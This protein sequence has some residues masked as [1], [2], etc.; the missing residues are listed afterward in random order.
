MHA[1]P[2]PFLELLR[3][4]C[5]IFSRRQAYEAGLTEQT[6]RS[7]VS[8]RRWVFLGRE[9]FAAFTGTLRPDQREWFAVLAAGTDACLSHD[10]AAFHHGLL[11]RRPPR[12]HVLIP[13]ERRVASIAGT[14]LHRTRLPRTPVGAPPR[15][16]VEDTICD[17]V[18][19]RWRRDRIAAVVTKAVREHL[20]DADRMIEAL[21]RR[22]RF[23]GSGML[24]GLVGDAS[25]GAHSALELRYL[26][27][28]ERAHGLPPGERQARARHGGRTTYRDV[29]YPGHGLTVELD[30]REH[31]GSF[32]ARLRDTRRDR[33]AAAAGELTL[34]FS[35]QEV[36]G[37]P[38]VVAAE[39]GAAL[40][41]RGWSGHPHPCR[42]C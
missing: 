25:S 39:V 9:V 30:G 41:D 29:H 35:W 19:A 8:A 7:Q 40:N 36:A 11:D 32:E 10:S 23:R 34:R 12:T 17:L 6:V 33:L 31:H 4:Q 16:D 5:G 13:F 28:V 37:S 27:D 15:T 3:A 18:L 20:T 38:C 21:G 24:R 14:S 26:R 1:L 2:A 42:L 22:G